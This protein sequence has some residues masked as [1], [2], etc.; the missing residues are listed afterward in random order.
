MASGIKISIRPD[1]ADNRSGGRTFARKPEMK[2]PIS[3]PTS[4]LTVLDPIHSS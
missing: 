2:V 1:P 4:N 3:K